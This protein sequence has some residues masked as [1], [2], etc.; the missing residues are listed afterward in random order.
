MMLK[1]G[2]SLLVVL[3]L[4]LCDDI[5]S[6]QQSATT[7]RLRF[8]A[9]S[10]KPSPKNSQY[11]DTSVWEFVPSGDV[12]FA[13]ATLHL[14]ISLAYMGDIRFSDVLLVGSLSPG[15]LRC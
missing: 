11:G 1:R 10:V 4:T 7:P 12:R 9:T 15:R 14:I 3:A 8:D 2:G 13:N 6:A 5:S